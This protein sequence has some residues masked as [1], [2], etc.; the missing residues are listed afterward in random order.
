M[1]LAVVRLSMMIRTGCMAASISKGLASNCMFA[2][3]WSFFFREAVEQGPNV[4]IARADVAQDHPFLGGRAARLNVTFRLLAVE[5]LIARKAA[6]HQAFPEFG[7][8]RTRL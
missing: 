4:L 1:Q 6:I 3:Q 8:A 5:P 2:G 7:K